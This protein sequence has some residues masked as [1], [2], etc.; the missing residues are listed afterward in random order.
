MYN[1]QHSLDYLTLE[2]YCD[3][4]KHEFIISHTLFFYKSKELVFN[5]N[6]DSNLFNQLISQISKKIKQYFSINK[7]I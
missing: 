3:N 4:I 6:I 7:I 2:H 5:E 1:K